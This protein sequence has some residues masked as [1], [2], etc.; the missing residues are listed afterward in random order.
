MKRFNPATGLLSQR[1]PITIESAAHKFAHLSFNFQFFD[2]SQSA[3]Q[4][5]SV[6]SKEQ[7]VKL[8]EKLKWYCKETITTGKGSIQVKAAAMCSKFMGTFPPSQILSTRN[9]YQLMYNGEDFVL[10]TIC[11]FQVLLDL[12]QKSVL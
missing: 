10:K 4:D 9:M 8:L 2:N 3:G 7:L 5:F 1:F 6:W 12:M 11:A